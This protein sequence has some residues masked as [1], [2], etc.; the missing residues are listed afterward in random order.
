MRWVAWIMIAVSLSISLLGLL[1]LVRADELYGRTQ[2]VERQMVWL[3]L[4]LPVLAATAL[5]PYRLLRPF[6]M[7]AYG[8]SLLLLT[9]VLFMPPVNGSRR[10][11]P[12]GLF[13][14]QAS[15]PARLA[16][17]LA[18]AAWLMHRRSQQSLRGLA[19][20]AGMAALP[21]LLIVREPDLD[22][23]LLFLPVLAAMLYAAGART[24]HLL[25]TAIVATACLPL[26]WTLM[27]AEQKS[28]VVTVFLQQDGGPAPAG[29]GFHLH[30]SR[31]VLAL[32]GLRG[33]WLQQ[34]PPI[35]DAAAWQL[36][37][38]RTDF[39]FVM[40]GERFG[41]AGC[42]LLLLLYSLL[43]IAG[44]IIAAASREP[45]GRLVAVGITVLLGVQ[46]ILNT[47]MTVGLLPITGTALP[48][49]SYGGSSLLCTYASIGM[50][51]NIGTHQSLE[52]TGRPFA[53]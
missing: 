18:L 53:F 9:T 10:W 19:A 33:S 28:R 35:E 17:V 50:L 32:G 6:S 12:L 21:M 39:I 34:E 40:I 36:P 44:L 37:A 51:I 26:L 23:A 2:L 52:A 24:R 31:Q 16:F 20:P 14:L 41:L 46:V 43:I 49:C 42:G 4:A 7:P 29:D 3:L 13:D 38:A 11:I 5:V 48:L 27:S 45:W 1:G 47:A 25:A 22:T 30:Q 8:L 15:E